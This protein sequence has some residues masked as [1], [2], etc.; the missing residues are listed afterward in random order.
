MCEYCG[1][2]GY[3]AIGCPN[4]ESK[5]PACTCAY[6]KEGIYNDDQYV[7]FRGG[8]YH[9]DCLREK[10]GEVEDDELVELLGLEVLTAGEEQGE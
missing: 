3:H 5:K 1:R 6:C 9:V 8:Q 2:V 4:A 7:S 10:I